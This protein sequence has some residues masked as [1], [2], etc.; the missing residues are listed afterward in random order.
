MRVQFFQS[1]S[2]GS[3]EK[4][5]VYSEVD[6]ER[7]VLIDETSP[8]Y[9]SF[10]L[11]ARGQGQLIIGAL[12]KRFSHGPFGEISLGSQVLRDSKRQ[13]IFAYFHPGDLKPP[14]NIYFSD[15]RPAEGFEGF[16]MMKNMGALL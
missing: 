11:E 3:L 14:L 15:Y 6:L 16:S 7:P 10:L 5:L 12:H 8:Y 1:G 2:L 9:L 4:E 13:E